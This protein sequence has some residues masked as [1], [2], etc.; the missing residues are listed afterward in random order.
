MN[1]W[2]TNPITNL[3]KKHL[4]HRFAILVLT[5]GTFLSAASFAHAQSVTLPTQYIYAGLT[6][7]NPLTYQGPILQPNRTLTFGRQ[8]TL[9]VRKEATKILEQIVI[10]PQVE[11]T[12][13]QPDIPTAIPTPTIYIQPTRTQLAV[14]LPVTPSIAKVVT[15][16]P[17]PTTP[18]V[19]SMTPGGLNP[20][21]LF[22][23]VNVYRQSH[24]LA[25]FQ[26]DDRSCSL[27]SSRAP[28]VASE[29]AAGTMHSGLKA[30]NLPY[31][32]TENIISMNSEQAAFNWWINDPIHHDA[33]VGNYTYSCVACSGNACAEE[34]TS[35][36]PK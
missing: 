16:T 3:M 25:S 7:H 23:M 22:S 29:I 24:R 19:A 13:A 27:A 2:Y 15:A 10:T 5:V 21:T 6:F 9:T 20:D 34:F 11:P 18:L 8:Q 33:I 28:E 4:L 1:T 12:V 31:W 26:K 30:R 14:T 32:N 36:Q 17:V 35:Y